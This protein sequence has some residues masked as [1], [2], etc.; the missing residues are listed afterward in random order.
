MNDDTDKF[1]DRESRGDWQIHELDELDRELDAAL[2]KYAAAEPRTG[3]E[4]RVLA[5]LRAEGASGAARAWWRWPA[6]VLLAAA[7]VIIV[8]LALVRKSPKPDVTAHHV[9][10]ADGGQQVRPQA[11]AQDGPRRAT[12]ARN[13]TVVVAP[14]TR[15][16][17]GHRI[18]RPQD[19]VAAMPK[20]D[21]FPSPQ[22]LSEQER[23]LANYVAQYPEKAVLVARAQTDQRRRDQIE[24]LKGFTSGATA[25][26][27][28]E[29]NSD[30]TDR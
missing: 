22:P 30:T 7:V 18:D 12:D 10:A 11:G 21:Q 14:A 13:P 4:A 26:D 6:I 15:R 9:S 16:K 5:N 19:I 25:N 20:L 1:E 29:R 3:L 24:E 17:A 28:D 27:S 8:G 23:I 2:A